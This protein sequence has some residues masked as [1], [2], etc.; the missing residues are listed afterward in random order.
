MGRNSIL[1]KTCKGTG[2][3]VVSAQHDPWAVEYLSCLDCEGTGQA[4]L[5]EDDDHVEA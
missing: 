3:V 2:V 4:P 5:K 1:C